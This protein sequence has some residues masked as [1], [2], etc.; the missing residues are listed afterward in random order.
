VA[1]DEDALVLVFGLIDE[2]GEVGL[3]L[4]K[5]GLDH[6]TIMNNESSPRHG[7]RPAS[8][9]DGTLEASGVSGRYRKNNL[10][11]QGVPRIGEVHWWWPGSVA[12]RVFNRRRT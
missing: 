9:A 12:M 2:R 11:H 3:G 7:A 6:V 8:W 10:H 1:Q 4:G 5:R